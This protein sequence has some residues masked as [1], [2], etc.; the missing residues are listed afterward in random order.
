MKWW[1]NRDSLR[2]C[3][4]NTANDLTK[5]LD[6]K[7]GIAG[8]PYLFELPERPH[9]KMLMKEEHLEGRQFDE[10]HENVG[11]KHRPKGVEGGLLEGG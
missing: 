1:F 2:D 7:L 5:C 10:H 4:I 8:G 11:S 3:Q 9:L 6:E